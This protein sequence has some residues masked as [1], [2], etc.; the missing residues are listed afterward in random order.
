M[1]TFR[2]L[3]IKYKLSVVIDIS[4]R[5]F[6]NAPICCHLTMLFRRPDKLHALHFDGCIGLQST[7]QA[8]IVV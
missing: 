8:I 3:F 5:R 2:L 4:R 6:Q 7:L 1:V